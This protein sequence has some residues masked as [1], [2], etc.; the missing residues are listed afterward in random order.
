MSKKITVISASLR[1]RS[2]SDALADAFIKGAREAGN[3]VEKISLSGKRIEFCRG[4]LSC[5]NTQKC[6]IRD[7]VPEI[8]EKIGKSDIVAFATPVYY[9]GMSGLLKT[10][11]DRCNPLYSS[12]YAFRKVYLLATAADSDESAVDGTVTGMNGWVCCFE[13]AELAGTVFAGGVNEP[14]EIN[15]HPALQQAYEAGKNA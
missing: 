11:L 13:K 1:S 14:G 5:Q 10:V 6:V 4:C 7:D 15:G 12:D 8:A 9:Y 2:N 3:E